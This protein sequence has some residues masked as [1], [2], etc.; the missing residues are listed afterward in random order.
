M[1]FDVVCQL[2]K[3]GSTGALCFC[4]QAIRSGAVQ[5]GLVVWRGRGFGRCLLRVRVGGVC[6]VRRWV[7]SG[8]C[9]GS[10][11]HSPR[12]YADEANCPQRT[13]WA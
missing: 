11:V 12:V 9:G 2:R 5:R 1:A 3:I 6:R 8:V 10:C 7:V 4:V 13:H